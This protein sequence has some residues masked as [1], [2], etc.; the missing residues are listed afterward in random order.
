ML[1]ILVAAALLASPDKLQVLNGSVA[2][3]T[4]K[5]RTALRLLPLSGHELSDEDMLAIVPGTDFEDGTIE[6]DVAGAPHEGL[7]GHGAKGFVGLAFRVQDGGKASELFYVR[8]VNGRI[9]DQAMRNHATQ[10]MSTPGFGWRKLREESPSLYESYVDLVPGEWTHL[11][12]EIAGDKARFYVNGATQ[13]TLIV[14][15]LKRGRS[16]GAI[17]LWAHATTDAYFSGL[18]ISPAAPRRN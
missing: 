13:P 10:Y 9:E 5:G 18:V 2:Q 11:R 1:T 16:R 4:W 6:V 12:M 7:A 17:A 15:D 3:T 14:N 8:P